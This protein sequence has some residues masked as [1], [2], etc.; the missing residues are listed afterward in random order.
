[1]VFRRLGRRFRNLLNREQ[2][3]EEQFLHHLN[4]R[5]PLPYEEEELFLQ[6][7]PLT[8]ALED[9]KM[10]ARGGY[11]DEAN[12]ALAEH[13]IHRLRPHSF[14]NAGHVDHYVEALKG[15]PQDCRATVTQ[16]EKA[17]SHRF[18]PLG[19]DAHTFPHAIDWFSD[20]QGR[21]WLYAH[22]DDL[23]DRLT[24]TFEQESPALQ[25]M[26]PVE[27]TWS[28]NQLSH[29]VDLGRAYWITDNEPFASEFVVQ[30]VDWGERNQP[31]YGINWMHPRTVAT[32]ALYWT[33]AFLMFSGSEQMQGDNLSRIL[34]TLLHHGGFLAALLL[35]G[36]RDQL[37]V[38][39]SLY[40]LA[41]H[42]PEFSASRRWM[43]MAQQA[44]EEGIG[45]EF[46]KD[47]LHRSASLAMH[48]EATEWILLVSAFDILNSR[49][50]EPL[51]R[52][53]EAAVEALAYLRS[54]AAMGCEIGPYLSEGLL[55]RHAGP[56]EHSRRIFALAA[57]LLERGDLAHL[58]GEAP[59]ELLWWLGPHGLT[60]Y[61]QL[62]RGEPTGVRRLFA[63]ANLAVVR[64][65]WGLRASWCMLRGH[66]RCQAES[67]ASPAPATVPWHDDDLALC[68]VL[69]G[70][71]VLLDAGTP[72]A[73][74]ES[75]EQFWRLSSHSTPRIGREIEPL[76]QAPETAG[77]NPELQMESVRDGYYLK[78][79]RPVWL[80]PDQPTLIQREVLF[81]PKKQRMI[82]RDH[83]Q[84]SGEV[85]FESNLLLGPQLDVLMRGDMGCLLRGKKLQA[86]I[87][88]LFPGRF[89]YEL[90]KGRTDPFAGWF[91]SEQQKPTP[92]SLLRYYA[93]FNAPLTVVLWFAWNPEDT[94]TPRI[95]DVDRLFASVHS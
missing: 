81:L 75:A 53:L 13:F 26:G 49:A 17:L 1:M 42:F 41:G 36:G 8:A 95:Q 84:G 80:T 46:A 3:L 31:M 12:R 68:L 20:L 56:I 61:C 70:E 37:A 47:G 79:E 14:L 94:L 32:R 24:R 48:R 38:A 27:R 63:D 65:H 67:Y 29:F 76:R 6:L 51:L 58:A 23:Q 92:T 88:P 44:L 10:S 40:L 30:A 19:C 35:R 34:R 69:D 86:R 4:E 54:P 9:A 73:L 11:F 7:A 87:I 71:P 77:L 89:R 39:A 90:L 85:H 60:D 72:P 18:S 74:G 33:I 62:H 52:P 2:N 59:A 45:R 15:F 78:G 16:A 5:T 66:K 50:W 55:G 91:W 25:Q 83:Y 28:F 57:V 43:V 22:V 93:R 21:S 64:D 82:L